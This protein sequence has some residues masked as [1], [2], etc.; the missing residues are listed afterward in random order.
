MT[1]KS[2][3]IPNYYLATW[4]LWHYFFYSKLYCWHSSLLHAAAIQWFLCYYLSIFL[5]I[6]IFRFLQ[7]WE[8]QWAFLFIPYDG[9]G[10]CVQNFPWDIWL[11]E[12]LL[13]PRIYEYSSLQ[14]IVTCLPKWLQY[15]IFLPGMSKK[16]KFFGEKT[17]SKLVWN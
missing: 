13:V 7:L 1:D 17:H 3:I 9:G 5:L 15:S 14:D 8:L 6:G 12:K 2:V 10:V 4:H 11:A 16:N